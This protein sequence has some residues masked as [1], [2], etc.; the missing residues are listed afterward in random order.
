ML[1]NQRSGITD[2]D[3]GSADLVSFLSNL[4]AQKISNDLELSE[5]ESKVNE[6][7]SNY[8]SKGYFDQTFLA[9]D[10][11]S[12]SNSP[13]SEIMKQLSDLEVRKIVELQKKSENHPDII[14]LDNQIAQLKDKLKSYNQN[15]LNSY[16]IIINTLKD[17]KANLESLIA[18]YQAKIHNVPK[19]ETEL[20]SLTRNA[21]SAEKMFNVLL[22]K[23]E[24]MR[25]KEISQ[26]QDILVVDPA[27]LPIIPISPN[28]K[29]IFLLCLFIWGAFTIGYVFVGEFH[30]RRLLKLGEIEG[31]LQ[32]PILSIIPKFHKRYGQENGSVRVFGRQ[33]CCIAERQLWN[34]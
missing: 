1:I 28:L 17:K 11:S 6:I 33:V 32:L 19:E 4:Q 15:T 20:A 27:D 23:R 12:Q 34:N 5:Y 30:E 14:S 3:K 8:K 31:E 16:N 24:E 2:L 26:L 21:E 25:I 9:P 13:F 7:Q 18:K 10:Q 22:D 29:I